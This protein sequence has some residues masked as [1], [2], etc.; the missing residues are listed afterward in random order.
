MVKSNENETA[1][2][3]ETAQWIPLAKLEPH[4]DAL[5]FGADPDDRAILDESVR[6]EGVLS[7]VVVRPR[8]DGKFEILDGCGRFA[9]SRKAGHDSI[10]CIVVDSCAS[11]ARFASVANTVHRKITTGS[12]VLSYV[13]M[14]RDKVMAAIE[15]QDTPV[16]RA[17]RHDPH[18]NDNGKL[19]NLVPKNLKAWTYQGI[20]DRLKVSRKD[21]SYA[22]ELMICQR[23]GVRP[24]LD[25]HGG[26][27]TREEIADPDVQE[28]L[29]D[30]FT[31]VLMGR[32][33]MRRWTAAFKGKAKTKGMPKLETV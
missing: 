12:R 6:Q 3:F 31:A 9:A 33:P 20:A 18:G 23:D 21:V 26:R 4:P 10:P 30:T 29:A 14:H 5:S 7:P 1:I 27:A 16:S 22:V 19:K 24:V 8:D 17:G 25:M 13:M 32:L 15:A 2:A 28:T 11:P